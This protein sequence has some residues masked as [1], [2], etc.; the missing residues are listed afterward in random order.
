MQHR[1]LIC[2][3]IVCAAACVDHSQAVDGPNFDVRITLSDAARSQLQSAGE[4]MR[5]TAYFDGNSWYKPFYAGGPFRA[6]FL[7]KKEVEVGLDE[8]AHFR[9]ITFPGK[10]FANLT[11]GR[12]Y[13][14][15]NVFSARRA[16][17]NNM[18]NC[19]VREGPSA[20]FAAQLIEVR[21]TP[22]HPETPA[23]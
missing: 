18:L 6:V 5:V 14:T 17:P 19:N 12:Y 3:A 2:L 1:A 13:V 10:E 8:V 23:T 20:Q 22:N 21:C 11:R 4:T 9:G 15:I 7:G 16:N